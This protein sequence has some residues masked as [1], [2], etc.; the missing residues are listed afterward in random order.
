MIRIS[1]VENF[2]FCPNP[3]S[4]LGYPLIV[5]SNENISVL[6]LVVRFSLNGCY[7]FSDDYRFSYTFKIILQDYVNLE[8]IKKRGSSI[9][10]DIHHSKVFS[11]RL[12]SISIVNI[13]SFYASSKIITKKVGG[14]HNKFRVFFKSND[15]RILLKSNF[16]IWSWGHTQ[17]LGPIG[18]AV[19]TFIS[20]FSSQNIVPFPPPFFHSD[21]ICIVNMCLFG[22]E[23]TSWIDLL[24]HLMCV[25]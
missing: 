12:S 10:P 1:T 15:N 14:L 24:T 2:H 17:N 20:Q 9:N 4:L 21:R 18:S 25:L 23:S 16:F 7:S 13:F 3:L 11:S 6:S 22:S 5:F 19:L 8:I